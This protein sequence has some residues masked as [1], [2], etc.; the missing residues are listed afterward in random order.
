MVRHFGGGEGAGIVFQCELTEH[1]LLVIFG[2]FLLLIRL[3]DGLSYFY[4]IFF[5]NLCSLTNIC[6][7]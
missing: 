2:S 6:T 5:S 3:C 7:Y 1:L 4:Q